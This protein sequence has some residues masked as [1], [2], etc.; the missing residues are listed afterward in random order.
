MHRSAVFCKLS[1]FRPVSDR[2]A[3]ILENSSA[4][5]APMPLEAPVIK[6]TFPENFDPTC[7]A[8]VLK[9]KSRIGINRC[10]QGQQKWQIYVPI[11]LISASRSKAYI[12]PYPHLLLRQNLLQNCLI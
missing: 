5:A 7:E 11:V 10:D 9:R 3:P 6:A 2:F 8:I 12:H 1:K 4:V